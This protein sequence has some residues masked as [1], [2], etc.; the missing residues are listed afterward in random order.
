MASVK[1]NVAR[2]A[3]QVSIRSLGIH[4]PL[5]RLTGRVDCWIMSVMSTTQT[6]IERLDPYLQ[7]DSEAVR[8]HVIDGTPIDPEVARRV[9]ERADRITEEIRRLHGEID[10]QKLLSEAREEV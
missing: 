2:N 9:D 4:N 7:A 8:R 5:V 1:K 6:E 10:I 3:G